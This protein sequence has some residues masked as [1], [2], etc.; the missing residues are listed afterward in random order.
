MTRAQTGPPA[1]RSEPLTNRDVLAVAV[2]IILSNVTTPLIGVVDTAVLGQLGDPHYIGAV[3][4][5]AMI[6]SML[7]WGFGFLRMGTTGLTA[8]SEG[9]GDGAEVVATLTRAL[10]IAGIAGVG[11][12]ALQGPI[13]WT[14]FW[15]VEGSTAVEGAAQEYL[16]I[17]IWS[18]PAALAN[19]A[20]LGWFIGLGKAGTAFKLQLILNGANAALDAFFVMGLG[21][22]VDGVAIGTVIA[23]CL[24]AATGLWLVQVELRRRGIRPDLARL[25]DSAGL[26]RAIAVNRD[27]M[28]RNLCLIFAFCW[29]TAQSAAGG[30]LTLAANAVLLHF[31]HVSA[32]FLDGF[33]FAAESLIGKSVGAR[34]PV[35]FRD[36]VWRSSAWAVLL[37][38]LT[39]LAFWFGGGLAIDGLTVNPE[40]RLDARDYLMWVALAP[41]LGVACFQLDGIFIGATRTADMRDMMIVSMIVYLAAW[42]ALSTAFGNHGLWASILVF[43]VVRATTLWLR[44]PALKRDLFGA[45]ALNGRADVARESEGPPPAAGR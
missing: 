11:L 4:V 32:F 7:F 8:Q 15:L 13:A 30:D 42:W 6:F 5:G 39:S 28:I 9:A 1:G 43:F 12:I 25:L 17:R 35:R 44:F 29:F 36:A 34:D 33:A 27:I 10:F 22:T 40:V 38:A 19:Y 26:A 41:I 3:A 45:H 2:P 18:A 20:I 24:T 23:E 14:A 31:L 16:R 37:A 21:M